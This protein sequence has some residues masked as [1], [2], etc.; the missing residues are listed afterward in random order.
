M[1]PDGALH[2]KEPKV[3]RQVGFSVTKSPFGTPRLVQE[4]RKLCLPPGHGHLL[5][6]TALGSYSELRPLALGS[7]NWFFLPCSPA[8]PSAFVPLVSFVSGTL[9]KLGPTQGLRVPFPLPG[10]LSLPAEP[11]GACSS[12]VRPCNGGSG[13]EVLAVSQPLPQRRF[14][15]SFPRSVSHS[16]ATG[17]YS[18]ACPPTAAGL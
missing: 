14:L 1:Q 5:L 3:V 4:V 6:T 16:G 11:A 2:R 8:P 9:A 7:A 12:P 13:V 15:S 10:A 17:A 18:C